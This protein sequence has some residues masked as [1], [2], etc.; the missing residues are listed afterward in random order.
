LIVATCILCILML[1]KKED[2]NPAIVVG[3]LCS[4]VL[5]FFAFR[6][7]IA[8]PWLTTVDILMILS[9]LVLCLSFVYPK[10]ADDMLLLSKVIRSDK[11]QRIILG[12]NAFAIT[13]AIV[14][15]LKGFFE[16]GTLFEVVVGSAIIISTALATLI[17]TFTESNVMNAIVQYLLKGNISLID[18]LLGKFISGRWRFSRSEPAAQFFSILGDLAI[19]GTYEQRRRIS[20]ALPALFR[21][22]LEKAV[23]LALVLRNDWD[24]NWRS[25]IRRRVV[26]STPPL[27]K[28]K[29]IDMRAFLDIRER[30]EVFTAMAIAEVA[31]QWQMK[32]QIGTDEFSKDF[33]SRAENIYSRQEVEGLDELIRIRTALK[34]GINEAIAQMESKYRSKN[35]YVRI[36]IA[37]QIPIVLGKYPRKCLDIM[38]SYSRPEEHVWVRRAL[39]REC[40]VR[41]IL[42]VMSEGRER[43]NREEA[44]TILWR[45]IKDT[46]DI[47]RITIFDMIDEIAHVDATLSQKVLDYIISNEKNE[48]LLGRARRLQSYPGT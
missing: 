18:E 40:S 31:T 14:L 4:L 45:L 35:L 24:E 3:G 23:K 19:H 36:G 15:Y 22:K 17:H 43:E 6:N 38:Q 1:K 25:D 41:S 27:L 28:R 8:P 37:R 30:D 16:F 34:K 11:L 39:A 26:E 42:K 7:S 9:I 12:A 48:V 21:W 29:S 13:A 46:D 33:R 10:V 44:E 5:L 47:I 32:T 2:N 20:E